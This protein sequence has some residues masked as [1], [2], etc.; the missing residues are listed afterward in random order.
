MADAILQLKFS[1]S[2][3]VY[4]EAALTACSHLLASI[5]RL[6]FMLAI[7]APGSLGLFQSSED[8]RRRIHAM[9][10]LPFKH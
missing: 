2:L 7:P 4:R 9:F 10:I 6:S 1:A 3:S 5:V 8:I